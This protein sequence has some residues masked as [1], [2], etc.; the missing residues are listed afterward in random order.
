VKISL[1]IPVLNEENSIVKNI[2]TIENRI[3]DPKNCEII[4]IDGQSTD[5]TFNL[6][7]ANKNL[8]V[9]Q[10]EKGRGKQMNF[11][12]QK[13]TGDILYFL[14]ID[15]IPPLHFDHEILNAIKANHSVGCF[16]MK[17]NHKHWWLFLAGWFTQF[18]LKYFRGGDQSLFITKELF[19]KTGGFKEEAQ[20]FEDYYFIRK[21]YQEHS[22]HVIQKNIITS[23]RRY[24]DNGVFKLQYHF[25]MLYIKKWLGAS[26]QALKKYYSKNIK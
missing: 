23:A 12:A 16:K 6:I 13:A 7:T 21:L 20:I 3:L 22:F 19:N 8:K 14:H 24:L 10:S 5:Q 2:K 9:Y 18:N 17:F 26:D 4:I 11:G 15:S 1:I 25:W